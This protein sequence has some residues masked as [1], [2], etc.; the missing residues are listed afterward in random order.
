[1]KTEMDA[2]ECTSEA[3]IT[4]G[5]IDSIISISRVLARRDFSDRHVIEALR[6]LNQ[7]GDLQGIV[8]AADRV[9]P[10]AESG[11]PSDA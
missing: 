11:G 3:G 6:D 7:D 5:L 9:I 10:P 4:V 1:M 2:L 8:A